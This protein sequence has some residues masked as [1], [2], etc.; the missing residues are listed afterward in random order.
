MVWQLL[1]RLLSVI[2]LVHQATGRPRYW[3]EASK[4]VMVALS[5]P[6]PRQVEAARSLTYLQANRATYIAVA[7]PCQ[8][9]RQGQPQTAAQDPIAADSRPIVLYDGV[10]NL[11]NSTGELQRAGNKGV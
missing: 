9:H 4:A 6:A 11:C 1:W 10:C 2:T 7:C 3:Q 5:T 8:A